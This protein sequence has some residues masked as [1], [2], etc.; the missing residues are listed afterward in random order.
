[1][2]LTVKHINVPRWWG[3]G[4]ACVLLCAGISRAVG[5][6]SGPPV[7]QVQPSSL[8]VCSNGNS[9]FESHASGDTTDVGGARRWQI[10]INN[11]VTF[12]NISG[13]TKEF[14]TN[15]LS[16]PAGDNGKIFRIIFTNN[17]GSVTS[18]VA[19]LTVVLPP[20]CSISGN[21]LV[22]AGSVGNSY[23]APAGMADYGW[24]VTGNATISGPTNASTVS[25]NAGATNTFTLNLR[26][27][28]SNGC[29]SL[30]LFTATNRV[31]AA[32]VTG[33]TTN[34]AGSNAVLQAALLGTAPWTLMWS[35]GFVQTTNASPA[36]RTVAS[37]T[38]TTYTVTNVTDALCTGTASGSATFT[39]NAAPVVTIAPSDAT[40]CPGSSITFTSAATSLTALTRRWQ[41]STNGGSSYSDLASATNATF[42][43]T[44]TNADNGKLF[45]V[46]FTNACGFTP[47]DPA[48][49]TVRQPVGAV[50]SGTTNLCPGGNVT[51]SLSVTGTPPFTYQW[52][53]NNGA[54]YT[55][56]PAATNVSLTLTAVTTNAAGNY[57]ALVTGPCNVSTSGVAVLT[58]NPAVNATPLNNLVR[59]TGTIAIFSTTASGG[60][61][62]TNYVWSRDGVP[63]PGQTN[64]TLVLSNLLVTDSGIYSVTANAGCSTTRSATL[65]VADCFPMLDLVVVIDRSGSMNDYGGQPIRD[66]RTAASN[67]IHN[68]ILSTNADQ[69]ALVSFNNTSTLD[70]TLTNN[71][72]RLEVA[73]GA[74]PAPSGGT[75]ISCGLSNALNELASVRHHPQAPPVVVLMTDG[76][77][78]L[79]DDTNTIASATATAVKS[80]G[81]R[82]FIIGLGAANEP[83]LSTLASAPS[84]FFLATNSA[85]LAGFFNSISA[86]LCRAPTNVVATGPFDLTVCPGT[87]AS[88]SVTASNCEP[89]AYQWRQDGVILSA[90]TNGTLTLVNV[91]ANQA[92]LYT[93]EV[94]NACL[95]ATNSATLTVLAPTTLTPLTS[96]SLC[97]GQT[98]IF[99]TTPS[100][101]GP[102]TFAWRRDGV[103]INGATNNSY[104]VSNGT[105]N[106]AGLYSVV[107]SGGCGS[108]TNFATL[109]IRAATIATPLAALTKCAG[110]TAVFATTPSGVG[111]FTYVWR[112][113]GGVIADATNNS[114]T[115]AALVPA[116]A[117]I[118]TVEVSGQCGSVTNSAALTV[119]ERTAAT[120]LTGAT[121]CAGGSVLFAT[122]PSGVGPFTFVWR[123]NDVAL[124]GATGNFLSLSNLSA[125]SAGTYAVE[126]SGLCGSVTNSA[127]LVVAPPTTASPLTN[128]TVCVGAPAAF[129]TV[130]AGPG[131][132]SYAWRRDGVL[133]SGET[134]DVLNIGSVGLTNAGRYSVEVTGGCNNVTNHASLIVNTLTSASALTDLMLCPNAAASFDTVA[135]GT[136]PFS[137]AWRR[138]GVLLPSETNA[139]LNIASV[140]AAQAGVYRV[141]VSGAC[142]RVTNSA[143]LTL[144]LPTTAT[145]LTDA[146]ACV[147]DAVSFTTT[148]QG[149][150]SFNYAWRRDGVLL[151]GATNPV[152]NISSITV[153]NA[154][155]YTVEVTGLCNSVTNSATLTVREPT[156]ATPF[157][158]LSL[159][160]GTPAWFSTVASG[161]GPFT[162]VW[163]RNNVLLSGETNATLNI[164]SVSVAHAGIYRVEVSGACNRVTN[165]ATL[166]VHQPTTATALVSA[167]VCVG[168]AVSFATAGQGTGPFAHVWRRD[169]VLLAGATNAVLNISSVGLTNTGIYTVEVFG[170]CNSVTNSATLTVRELTTATPFE[171]LSLCS[172]TPAWFSTVASGSGPFTYAWSR[173]NALLAGETN[174]TLNIESV[175]AAHAGVY[176]VEVSGSCNRVTNSATLAVQQPTTALSMIDATVCVGGAVSFATAGQ[177]TGPFTYLWRR[178]GV[179]L[180]GETNAVL[181]LSAI[182]TAQ[183]GL[184]TAEVAGPCNAATNRAS[185]TV[186]ERTTATPFAPLIFACQN[187]PAQF[188]TIASGTGPFTFAWRKDGSLL[189][190]ETNSTLTL[191]AVTAAQAGVYCVEISGACNRVTNGTVLTVNEL[192]TAAG[193]ADLEVY[194][195]DAAQFTVIPVGTGPFTF[196]WRHDGVMLDGET[197]AGLFIASVTAS[198]AGL[199]TVEVSGVCGSA[200]NSATLMVDEFVSATAL[201]DAAYCPGDSAVFSTV[202]SG[203]GPFR[204]AWRKNAALLVGETNASLIMAAVTPTQSGYYTVEVSGARN[205]VTN[206]ALLT[207]LAPTTSGP[208]PE[209]TRCVAG[210]ATFTAIP[211]GS[212]PFRYQ[213]SKGGSPLAA[214]TN[215]SLALSNLTLADAGAYQVVITGACAQ[216]S[217]TVMLAISTAPVAVL[218]TNQTRCAGDAVVFNTLNELVGTVSFAWRK[219]A[220]LMAGQTNRTLTLTNLKAA[221]GATYF[222][223][224]TDDCGSTTNSAVLTVLART[225]ATPLVSQNRCAGASVSFTTIPTGTAPFSFIWRKDGVV[226]PGL[227]NSSITLSGLAVSQAGLY[228]VEVSGACGSATNSAT[229][230]VNS[231]PVV[232]GL[233]NV[234]ACVGQPVVLA[235]TISGSGLYTNVWRRNGALVSGATNASLSLASVST[236]NAGT[237]ALEVS[238][239]CGRATNTVIVSLATNTVIAAL[240]G[241]TLCPGATATFTA[242]VTGTG[243]FTYVWRKDGAVLSNITSSVLTVGNVSSTSAGLYAVE[244]IG[245]CNSAGASA[246]LAVLAPTTASALADATVCAGESATFSTTATGGGA[247]LTCVWRKDGVLLPGQTNVTLN[248]AQCAVSH[249]GRYSVEVTGCNTVTNSAQLT[250]RA[251]LVVSMD[252]EKTAC[253]CDDLVL[254]PTILGGTGPFTYQW[255][256][257]GALLEGET[258]VSLIL[259]RLNTAS[260]GTYSIDISSPCSAASFSTLLKVITLT[261]GFWANTNS[262][263]I[264]GFGRASPY[265]SPIQVR[266]APKLV[267]ELRVSLLGVHHLFPEDLD[268]L[269][270]A[271]DGTA[272]TVMSDVGGGGAN[273][274]T[275]VDL[276]FDDAAL[277]ALTG[278]QI[279]SGTYRPTD[280]TDAEA[281][282]FPSPAPPVATIS[283]LSQF[284]GHNQNGTWSLYVY[285]DHGLD[286]G[287]IARGWTLDFGH[288]QFIQTDLSLSDPQMMLDGACRME[289][290]GQINKTY[291]LEA[292]TNLQNWVI[293][294]TNVL[295][296]A[297]A[298]LIDPTAAQHQYRFYRATGCRD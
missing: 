177:G 84:D 186:L 129:S 290:K 67:I 227:N 240:T 105:T 205:T 236:T 262:I 188:S 148:G 11:G 68:L 269:L 141:E 225:G 282:L 70:Q 278:A 274:I 287:F 97:A 36:R 208:V 71:E 211:G 10:S 100:G 174:A 110:D 210:E 15:S 116:A 149:T 9:I 268:I 75:C 178:D 147:G 59:L 96:Q 63:L 18:T 7:M 127:P 271:P 64:N 166:T 285:D 25:I 30:C 87:T 48:Q 222:V 194:P 28:N 228:S 223:E 51:F 69:A 155:L 144:H 52:Q 118:Y 134:N 120:P 41:I 43:L 103:L 193:L 123:L 93:V 251:P 26:I 296:A 182:T 140:S 98:A 8:A 164:A 55:N 121:V 66:A 31:T 226:L 189:A 280:F 237:Y 139:L 6:C 62:P 195:G 151:S 185:L 81:A 12:S 74:I 264:S 49:L 170:L 39:V 13:A 241:Q 284:N 169:G 250:V 89:N 1:M 115:L 47:S 168:D 29:S 42:A 107:V 244:V 202:T 133:L 128:V 73:V 58:V 277:N 24:S 275:N 56:I 114:I 162:Y 243:P 187:S 126:V 217:S 158:N 94:S 46:I 122:T 259:Q 86:T 215:I 256:K 245:S 181:N 109:T 91:Q 180:A 153:S 136:G 44:A 4:L 146:T 145:P 35:D 218:F 292:S 192:T 229:L 249:S 106:N 248:F 289:L 156:T 232:V 230:Q 21:S 104:T 239:G 272:L 19:L 291:F 253:S 219:G 184:Y 294:Q 204:Y 257:D 207:V 20:V 220:T 131:P 295:N 65:T 173:D 95:R 247:P 124:P 101:T 293:I 273:S 135:S 23:S 198:H 238:G 175:S 281:D 3:F 16:T 263:L 157:E 76:V 266:C 234:Q 79:P 209:Q 191:G 216:A 159:C 108:A 242:V 279:V 80:A 117:G 203:T 22:C 233:S 38:T 45:R 83:F 231:T 132:F 37:F 14:Y 255:R 199:Y 33:S 167:T 176:R 288:T 17:C 2:I 190:G 267:S 160:S 90:Q 261:S 54:S 5:A 212:G 77:P 270:V 252:P 152:L 150:G 254:G 34:C 206:G 111:P 200:T 112:H 172:G 197:N 138:D 260:P 283:Q 40:V 265:P 298:I 92:G 143:T 179:L 201:L 221:D 137:Y 196:V 286:M 61:G 27:V 102:F 246:T 142:N 82:L 78:R 32:T 99:S 125:A 88:F 57:R 119:V 60:T 154:G 72:P 171:N 214:A 163:S 165:G 224:I 276:V 183:A 85:Q 130:A 53:R 297:S 235:A 50:I 161:S 258:N 113:D 213:W